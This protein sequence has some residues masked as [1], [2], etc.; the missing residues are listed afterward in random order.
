MLRPPL[1]GGTL[2]AQDSGQSGGEKRGVGQICS[3]VR[4][5]ERCI[6]GR[7]TRKRPIQSRRIEKS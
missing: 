6:A 5:A 1:L 4:D 7:G 3:N 2:F